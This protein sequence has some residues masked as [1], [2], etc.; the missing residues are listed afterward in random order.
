MRS[1]ALSALALLLAILAPLATPAPAHAHLVPSGADTLLGMMAAADGLVV[2]RSAAATH[3]RDASSAATPFLEREVVAGNGPEGAFVLDQGPPILRYAEVQ[4]ALLLV[5]RKATAAGARWLSVQPAGAA[6]L[7]ASATLPDDTRRV[8][9]E[10]WRAAHP[11]AEPPD[12]ALTIAA[13]IDAL[14]LPEAKLRA[15]AFLDL[16]SLAADPAHFTP[17]AV[18]RLATYGNRPGD[19]AQLATAVQGLGRRLERDGARVATDAPRG[20]E[21]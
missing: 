5:Q 16:S 1:T 6:I 17:A 3:Q 15:L 8:L 20:G 12:P 11:G 13:L 2:A 7:L 21:P 4:D 19:D 10:L 18:T 9:R 14:A